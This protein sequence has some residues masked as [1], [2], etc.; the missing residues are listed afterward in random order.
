VKKQKPLEIQEDKATVARRRA[1]AVVGT[2]KPSRV[3]E[4]KAKRAPR[5]KKK[6][7]AEEEGL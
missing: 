7:G 5:H 2:V 1:R 3:M 6:A 4:P